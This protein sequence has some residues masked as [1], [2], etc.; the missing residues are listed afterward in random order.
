MYKENCHSLWRTWFPLPR[1]G[2]HYYR[3]YLFRGCG[4]CYPALF[5]ILENIIHRI[6][7]SKGIKNTDNYFERV[8]QRANRTNYRYYFF[9]YL[10]FKG[11]QGHKMRSRCS[12]VLMLSLYWWFIIEIPCI[13]LFDR[14]LPHTWYLL[15]CMGMFLFPVLFCLV[16]YRKDRTSALANRYRHS[17]KNKITITL[18]LLLPIVLCGFEL[19]LL[20][21]LGWI[22]CKWC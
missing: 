14:N 15:C 10:Y 4:R 17:S 7:M 3:L 9:D 21:K 8:K 20:A 19:W 6:Y 18:L 5:C 1:L 22:I 13:P 12:G 11:E 16:R 2:F